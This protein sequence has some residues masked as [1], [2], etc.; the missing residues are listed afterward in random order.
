MTESSYP[1]TVAGPMQE[2]PGFHE[3]QIRAYSYYALYVVSQTG[4]TDCA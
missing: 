1:G 3:C 4:K 2:S